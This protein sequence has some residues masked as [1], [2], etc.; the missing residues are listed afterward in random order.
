MKNMFK[1]LNILRYSICIAATLSY[2]SSYANNALY[3]TLSN[4][5]TKMHELD[6]VANNA[7]NSNTYGFEADKILVNKLDIK[8]NAKATNSFPVAASV[9]R[10]TLPGGIVQTG[11]P[12]DVCI[13]EQGG[14][15]KVQTTQGFRYTLNGAMVTNKDGLVV[16]QDGYPYVSSGGSTI[17]VAPNNYGIEVGTDGSVFYLDEN[18][19][20]N[21]SGT[22]GIFTFTPDTSFTKVGGY[23]MMTDKEGT[24]A[25][26]FTVMGGALRASNVNHVKILGDVIKAQKAVETS[27]TILSEILNLDKHTIEKALK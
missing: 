21:N 26:N 3:M 6:T 13:L 11:N 5:I 23:L 27:N 2:G 8:Q 1:Y 18:G 15:F 22:L 17:Q 7:A 25:S 20:L 10:D 12:L 19:S 4:H 14:Y 24:P 9:Y 16:N